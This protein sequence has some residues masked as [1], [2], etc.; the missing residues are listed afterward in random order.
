MPKQRCTI[1]LCKETMDTIH[2]AAKMNDLSR[3]AIIRMLLQTINHLPLEELKETSPVP[4]ILGLSTK[5][6]NKEN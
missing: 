2:K 5:T 3:S 4:Y 6:I 1:T